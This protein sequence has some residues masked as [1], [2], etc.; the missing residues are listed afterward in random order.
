MPLLPSF[1]GMIG[2]LSRF[3]YYRRKTGGSGCTSDK[4]IFPVS[5]FFSQIFPKNSCGE[6]IFIKFLLKAKKTD[7]LNACFLCRLR[8]NNNEIGERGF[9]TGF[10]ASSK[11]RFL[12]DNGLVRTR[13]GNRVLFFQL[14]FCAQSC[15]VASLPPSYFF[16]RADKVKRLLKIFQS[17]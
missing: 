13:A 12:S 11:Y 9:L 8:Y 6:K 7:L 17:I 10:H 1:E 14:R 15:F 5:I 2:K 3:H 4:K 16:R